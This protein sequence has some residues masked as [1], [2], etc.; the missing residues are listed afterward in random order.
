[1]NLRQL[2]A[3]TLVMLVGIQL[4]LSMGIEQLLWLALMASG[5]LGLLGSGLVAPTAILASLI[6]VMSAIAGYQLFA[7]LS[8]GHAWIEDH[9]LFAGFC[10]GLYINLLW[11]LSAMPRRAQREMPHQVTQYLVVVSIILFFVLPQPEEL[12]WTVVAPHHF[13]WFAPVVVLLGLVVLAGQRITV[14][15]HIRFLLMVPPLVMMPLV[16]NLLVDLRGP[17]ADLAHSLTPKGFQSKN[18]I[19]FS[20]FQSLNSQL[21]RQGTA[22]VVMRVRYQSNQPFYLV[23]NRHTLFDSVGFLWHSGE[24][25][26]EIRLPIRTDENNLNH[27]DIN[28]YVAPPFAQS[29]SEVMQITSLLKDESLFLPAGSR[30]I[31][32]NL[33]RISIDDRQVWHGNFNRDDERTWR[34]TFNGPS[35]PVSIDHNTLAL[36]EM[37]DV[38]LAEYAQ[39]FAGDSRLSVVKNILSHFSDK[40]YSLDVD[41]NEQYPIHDF[42]INRKAAFCYWY[43]TATTLMLRENGV[44]ARLVSGYF[45]DT[46]VSTGMWLVHDRDAHAWVEWQDEA[47]YWHTIDPTPPSL[48]NYRDSFGK[49]YLSLLF[50]LLSDRVEGVDRMIEEMEDSAKQWLIFIGLTILLVLFLREYRLIRGAKSDEQKVN[51]QWS[52]V[53]RKFLN[54]TRLPDEPTWSELEYLRHLPADWDAEYRA[55]VMAFFQRYGEERFSAGCSP[56]SS[57]LQA[58]LHN[59][60]NLAKTNSRD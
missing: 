46:Q 22:K 17:V 10:L 13:S 26:E 33:P 44:P 53:W 49:N 52:R 1:M 57:D 19:G 4:A 18:G 9:P 42:L 31:E 40:G 37:W 39:Q 32:V 38:V 12:S 36:P 6:C 14:R 28:D 54:A 24:Q 25:D 29:Q 7:G 50:H 27:F 60:K 3:T 30:T 2:P 45:V 51:Q 56:P 21:F 35:I 48:F 8:I 11:L 58:L 15:Q 59:L 55:S 16:S 34:V 43:A 41:I 23:G 47:G 20:P 5:L